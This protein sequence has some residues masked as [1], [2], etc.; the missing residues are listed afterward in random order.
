M[1][2]IPGTSKLIHVKEVIVLPDGFRAEDL[3]MC[4]TKAGKLVVEELTS[5]PIA[6]KTV[7][8]RQKISS[9]YKEKWKSSTKI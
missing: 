2:R 1:R 6:A 8:S 5:H 7:K 3:L 9:K 4:R